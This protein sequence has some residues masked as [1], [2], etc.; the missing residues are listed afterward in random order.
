MSLIVKIL[1]YIFPSCPFVFSCDW[2]EFIAIND[3][4]AS[5]FLCWLARPR[6]FLIKFLGLRNYGDFEKL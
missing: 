4:I 1:V 2:L 3:M 6:Y 5:L